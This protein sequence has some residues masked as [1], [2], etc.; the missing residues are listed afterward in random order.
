[1]GRCYI[2]HNNSSCLGIDLIL[3]PRG[4]TGSSGIQGI[5]EL[6]DNVSLTGPTGC[7][8]PAGLTGP[9]GI[10][11]IT[12][13]TGN[14]G[15]TGATGITGNTGA[16]GPIG[17]SLLLSSNLSSTVTVPD[18]N[19]NSRPPSNNSYILY[20]GQTDITINR[21]ILIHNSH[22]NNVT[23][24]I[25]ELELNDLNALESAPGTTISGPINIPGMTNAPSNGYSLQDIIIEPLSTPSIWL[26]YSSP[27]SINVQGLI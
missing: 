20:L 19:W 9:Q 2:N 23:F 1:M 16:T 25:I 11:G 21:T 13:A 6:Q 4:T 17:P 22:E 5:N 15:V 14:T 26:L 12:G 8:G 10:T 24:E 27:C 7:S 3:V 18:W